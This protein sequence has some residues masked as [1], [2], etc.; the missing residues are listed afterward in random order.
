MRW[1]ATPG[2]LRRRGVL[3]MNRRNTEMIATLNPRSHYPL[4]DDKLQ[5]KELALGAGIAVPELYGVIETQHDIRRLS[6]IVAG[7]DDFVIKPAHGSGGNGI[8]VITGR[9]GERF[10]KASGMLVDLDEVKHHVSNI[11]SG[12]YSLGGQPDR[13]MI[14]YRVR[15]DPLFAEV[16]FQGVPDIRTVVYKGYPVMAMV[17]LPTRASDGKANLHQGAVG[18]G[19]DIATGVTG[20]GVWHNEIVH[21]HPDTGASLA[22]IA[23]P[24]WNRLLELAAGCRELIGMGYLGVDVVLDRQ[25]GPLIL[26]LNARPGL[27]VQTANSLGLLDRIRAVDTHP[28]RDAADAAGRAAFVRQLPE[29][30]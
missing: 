9:M 21:R 13:A 10:R 28:A 16:S 7:R 1:F 4:V 18:A 8:L 24:G 23:V 25:F 27:A 22:G 19:I 15:F 11:L 5:T 26:E 3:G 14:E 17:R 29:P 20:H 30:S 2:E 12:M 6:A